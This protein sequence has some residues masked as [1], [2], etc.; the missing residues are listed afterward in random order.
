MGLSRKVPSL[1]PVW[2]LLPGSHAAALKTANTA[3]KALNP[4]KNNCTAL[5]SAKFSV[6]QGS[7]ITQTPGCHSKVN[8]NKITSFLAA[9]LKH[10]GKG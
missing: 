2:A 4:N 3:E 10:F 1:F 8:N 6:Q 5:A 9:L 7:I